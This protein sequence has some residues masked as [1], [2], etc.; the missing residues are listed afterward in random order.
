MTQG[1]DLGGARAALARPLL[2][3]TGWGLLPGDEVRY[4]ARAID[5][6]PVAHR[7]TSYNVCYT[8]LL[9]RRARA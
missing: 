5:N 8:K 9:R 6:A 1:L 7:I 4:H 2:D 3:L